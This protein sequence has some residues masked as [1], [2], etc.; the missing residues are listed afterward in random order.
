MAAAAGNRYPVGST[1]HQAHLHYQAADQIYVA[2]SRQPIQNQDYSAVGLEASLGISLNPTNLNLKAG[3]FFQLIRAMHFQ[4]RYDVVVQQA[5]EALTLDPIDP[6]I[7]FDILVLKGRA[8]VEISRLYPQKFNGVTELE[9]SISAF[10]NAVAI[11]PFPEQKQRVIT[12]IN[13]TKQQNYPG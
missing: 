5:E 9:K 4:K 1:D 3:L 2:Q 13:T 11:A 7:K 6:Q 12:L 8:H 10:K